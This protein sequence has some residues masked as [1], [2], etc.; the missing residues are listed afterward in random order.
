MAVDIWQ[1]TGTEGYN[2]FQV[3]P[4]YNRNNIAVE[5]VKCSVNVFNNEF[6]L[7]TL[8]PGAML[9]LAFGIEASNKFSMPDS[10]IN[11]QTNKKCNEP[12]DH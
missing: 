10:L 4:L 1:Q 6:G 12:I 8:A 5:P 11:L 3:L 7:I 2:F 9:C